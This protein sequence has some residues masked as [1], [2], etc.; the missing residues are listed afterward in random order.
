VGGLSFQP[1]QGAEGLEQLSAEWTL[2]AESIPNARFVHFPEWYRAY[3]WS[4]ETDR[5]RMWFVAA[6]REQKLVAV[7]PLQFQ[8][9]RIGWLRP[10]L[11]GS[12][13]HDEMQTSDFVF[14]RQ[15]GNESLVEELMRW[16]PSQRDLRWDEMRLRKVSE[17]SSIAFARMPKS[18]VSLMHDASS[19]FE[20][21]SSYEHATAAMSGTFRRNLRRLGKRAESMAP[22]RYESS[23]ESGE[24]ETAFEHF[25]DIEASGWKGDAGKSSA[26]RCRPDMLAF[27]QKLV[28]QFGAR[29][30]CV[31][32]LLWQGNQPVAGQFCLRIGN[33]LDVLKV[34]FNDACASFA[35]GNLLL[36]RTLQHACADDSIRVVSLVNAPP[37]ARVFKPLNVGVWSYYAPNRTFGGAVV[38]FSLL[39]KRTWENRIRKPAGAT[40]I[41]G[42]DAAK[43]QSEAEATT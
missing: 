39:A 36:E 2:L 19:Y 17:E 4:L 41:A 35:P 23:R 15:P 30:I 20:T 34:G 3:L 12:V 24:L 38:H 11:L 8:P 7:F 9:Y 18:T 32:N 26:I 1:Y 10:R 40:P 31:I 27:Y 22:L 6:R 16:L 37:W 21:H 25:L 13:D 43:A 5:S 33:R 28:Q 29:R 14:A 42:A